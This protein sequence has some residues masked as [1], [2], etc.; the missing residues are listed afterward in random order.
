MTVIKQQPNR[1]L[2]IDSLRAMTPGQRVQKAFELSDLTHDL[3][4]AGIAARY[5]EKSEQERHTVYLERLERCRK[6]GC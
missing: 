3:L 4:N 1:R 5:P 6:H 2:Y